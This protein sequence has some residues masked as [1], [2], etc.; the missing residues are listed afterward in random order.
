MKKMKV[1]DKSNLP[2]KLPIFNTIV[3][4]LALDY[5]NPPEWIMGA[6]GLLWSLFIIATIARFAIERTVDIF[7]EK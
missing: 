7:E 5:W 4:L 6:I 2:T 1:L 3:I